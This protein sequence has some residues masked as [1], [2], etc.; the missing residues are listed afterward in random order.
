[1]SVVSAS[2]RASRYLVRVGAIWHYRRY[3]PP[4]ARA[5]VGCNYWKASLKTGD[6]RAAEMKA[7]ALA[8]T[9]DAII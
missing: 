6:L 1:M 9:H 3:V 7:R 4:E 5:S 8:V 2:S